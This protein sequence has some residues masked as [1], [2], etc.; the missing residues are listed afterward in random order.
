MTGM[1]T[2]AKA[3]GPP[4]PSRPQAQ[5]ENSRVIDVDEAEFFTYDPESGK[6]SS[7]VGFY[8]PGQVRRQLL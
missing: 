2:T 1:A 4:R 6:L 5:P 8:D 7:V 3:T